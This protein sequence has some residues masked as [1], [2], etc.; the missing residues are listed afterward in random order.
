MVGDTISHYKVLGKLGHGGMGVVYRAKD[1]RL[2]RYVALKFLPDDVAH[3]PQALERFQREAKSA[4]ALNHP[5]ICTI[6]DIGESDGRQFIAMELLEGQTLQ[7]RI[8]H[9]PLPLE[10]L[11]DLATQIADGLAAAHAKGIIH[12]DIKPSN[13]FVTESGHA[14]ILDFGLASKTRSRSKAGAVYSAMPTGSLSEEHLTSPGSAVGTIAYMSPE[15]ARGEELDPRTDVFSFGAVLYEMATGRPPFVGQTSAVIFDGI[16]RQD[17]ISP[18]RLNPDLPPEI[19]H[20]IGKALEK[21]RDVRYQS[22]AE[23]RADLK[24]AK[25]DS[26]SGRVPLPEAPRR[27]KYRGAWIVAAIILFSAT[28]VAPLLWLRPR[29]P[30]VAL[31]SD[32]IQLTDFADSAV[33]PALSPDG[34]MLAFI[35]GPSTFYGAGE[36][37]VKLLPKGEPVAL[38]HDGQVKLDVHFSPDGSRVAYGVIGNWDTWSVPVLGGEPRLMLPNATG[39]TWTADRHVLFSE[40]KSGVHMAVVTSD[41]SRL[42]S[43]DVYVPPREAGMA[44]RSSLSPDGKWVL[45]AEMDNTSWLPCRLVPFDG[46]SAGNQVGPPGAGCVGVAW[47][48]DGNWMYM[49]SSAGGRHHI[50]RQKFPDGAPQQLTSGVSEEDGIAVAPDGQS[51]ITSVGSAESTLWVHDDRGERQVS[52]QGLAA[53]PQFSPDGKEIYYVVNQSVPGVDFVVGELRAVNLETGQVRRVLP[54]FSVT[55]FSVSPDGKRVA[56]ASPDPQGHSHLWIA[57]L[58]LRSAPRQLFSSADEDQPAFAS[59]G[60]LF[61]RAAEGGTNFVYRMKEDGSGRTKVSPGPIYSFHNISPDK[62]WIVVRA[63]TKGEDVR[64]VTEARPVA[65]GDSVRLCEVNCTARWSPGGKS[66]A[67]IMAGMGDTQSFLVPLGPGQSLPVVPKGGIRSK[68][69]LAGL[70][71]ATIIPGR[72]FTSSQPGVYAFLRVTVHRNLYRVPLPQ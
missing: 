27:S 60:E 16:L 37:Y 65:G 32:W 44:H 45:L 43:R 5:N 64:Y 18:A 67:F 59:D 23:L 41:E 68:A 28:V 26:S 2:E 40:I 70:K 24:R 7:E 1:T 35:R 49:V 10:E 61:F 17:P 48:P 54:D 69:D 20:I 31:S 30:A 11:L 46:S 38:T 12:R 42:G 66:F 51:L 4:S 58:D 34:R 22:A 53:A 19:E 25:R 14:K 55:G 39:L 57:A 47:S 71:G 13:I 6:Y 8:S 36:V 21:D 15:Q 72:I 9:R 29:K 62:K 63:A 52:S 56:V 33:S 3:D 50:W